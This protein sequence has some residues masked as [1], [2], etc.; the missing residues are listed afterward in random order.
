MAL[1]DIEKLPGYDPHWG[2]NETLS[3]A[4]RVPDQ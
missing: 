4:L 3:V 2:Q 1:M